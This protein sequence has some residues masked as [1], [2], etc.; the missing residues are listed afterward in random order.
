[1]LTREMHNRTIVE[2]AFREAGAQSRP[3]IETNSILTLALPVVEGDVCTVMPSAL[4]GAIRGYR[5]LQALPLIGPEV[6]T[7]IG[8]MAQAAARPSR[9]L[10]AALAMAHDSSWLR[11]A[12]PHSGLLTFAS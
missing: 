3:A 4:V 8:L 11:H 10:E 9:T 1:M 7:S 5:E 2:N 12:A 6:R